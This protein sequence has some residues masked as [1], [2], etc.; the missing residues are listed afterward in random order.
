MSAPYTI[1]NRSL[2]WA[3]RQ[4]SGHRRVNVLPRK[5]GEPY[6]A[7]C[8]RFFREVRGLGHVFLYRGRR[9]IGARPL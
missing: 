8:L 4:G 6:P 7:Y 3:D 9:R 5:H 1:G 2:G